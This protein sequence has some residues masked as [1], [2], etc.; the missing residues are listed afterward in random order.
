MTHV[1]GIAS[2]SHLDP[3]A[4]EFEVAHTRGVRAAVHGLSDYAL[5]TVR[6][7]GTAV[8]VLAEAAV[9][10]ATPYLRAPLLTRLSAVLRLHPVD[11][12][13]GQR[14]PSCQELVPCAT[15]RVVRG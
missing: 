1:T 7:S 15:A 10:S 14:C 9:S 3:L 4:Y 13:H 6:L 2:P 8:P 12:E 5:G 11:L